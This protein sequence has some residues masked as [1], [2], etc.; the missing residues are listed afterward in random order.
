M[1]HHWHACFLVCTICVD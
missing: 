1:A